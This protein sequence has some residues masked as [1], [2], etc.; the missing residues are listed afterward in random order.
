MAVKEVVRRD[1]RKK[2]Q[3]SIKKENFNNSLPIDFYS[4]GGVYDKASMKENT[5]IFN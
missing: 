3:S 2:R 1:K 5:N 4:K